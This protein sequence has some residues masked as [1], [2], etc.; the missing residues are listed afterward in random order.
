MVVKVSAEK[1]FFKAQVVAL[2]W[3]V[4]VVLAVE[5]K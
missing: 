1:D 2:G 5:N 3:P 4:V